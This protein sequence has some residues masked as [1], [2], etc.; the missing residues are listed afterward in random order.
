MTNLAIGDCLSIFT[1]WTYTATLEEYST[2]SPCVQVNCRPH[3]YKPT[4]PAEKVMDTLVESGLFDVA[5]IDV[6]EDAQ[7]RDCE[8]LVVATGRS[9]QHALAGAT[10]LVI[11]GS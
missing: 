7:Q 11:V 5:L 10:E 3:V 8:W 9:R 2:K 4:V 6:R 1:W